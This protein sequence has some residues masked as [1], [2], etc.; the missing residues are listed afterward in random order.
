[1]TET[2]FTKPQPSQNQ[3]WPQGQQKKKSK[4]PIIITGT[5]VIALIA[6][7]AIYLYL[8]S[9]LK[10]EAIN[11]FTI[12][13][14]HVFG[15]N[16]WKAGSYDFSIG[17]KKLTA[18]NVTLSPAKLDLPSASQVTIGSVEIV[19]GLLEDDM[20]E[21]LSLSSWNSPTDTHLADKLTINK[22]SVISEANDSNNYASI[23]A[24]TL[25]GLDL[26]ANSG[27]GAQGALSF[28]QSSRLGNVVVEH[29]AV[30]TSDSN[31]N[32]EFNLGRVEHTDLRLGQNVES[33]NDVI[34]MIGSYNIKE[35]IFRDLQFSYKNNKKNES[36]NVV[37]GEQT[38]KDFFN[39]SGSFYNLKNLSFDIDVKEVGFPM[40]FNFPDLTVNKFDFLPFVNR[41]KDLNF[42]EVDSDDVNVAL[43]FYDKLYRL[44]DVIV[45]PY[46]FDSVSASSSFS[47]G[48]EFTATVD[49]ATA[50]GPFVANQVPPSASYELK[51][52]VTLPT[53]EN[54]PKLG[55]L[56][57]FGKEFGQRIFNFSY[58][59]RSNYDEKTSTLTH[60][61]A[62]LVKADDLFSIGLDF[63]LVNLTPTLVEKMSQTPMSNS[64]SLLF[65]PEMLE[66]G[67]SRFRLEILDNSLVDK[68]FVY[69]AKKISFDTEALKQFVQGTVI[70]YVEREYSQVVESTSEIGQQL[71][72]FI[73]KPGSLVVE[74]APSRPLSISS[75]FENNF[76]RTAIVNSL[77]GTLSVNSQTPISIRLLP[78]PVPNFPDSNYNGDSEGEPY[79]NEDFNFETDGDPH[80]NEDNDDYYDD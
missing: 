73:D 69:A 35:S 44:S 74:I 32:A 62:P 11:S 66:L 55:I 18:N 39:F 42:N 15:E 3:Q 28:I 60:T 13:M 50:K 5:L 53:D 79:N 1:M 23:E 7:G 6:A 4:L 22:A 49:L 80:M 59:I 67:L 52:T 51:G 12:L 72:D 38:I 77:N 56:A 41:F 17:G 26:V 47:L 14:D 10:T 33:L 40:K 45:M 57:T 54:H 8:N 31:Q 61:Y 25:T 48:D 71:S 20:K 29:V 24:V 30:K 58:N 27:Q 68:T 19:N 76:D 9:R 65:D 63:T 75:A 64:E 70:N 34:G 2:D 36:F 21:L 16:N 43:D 37:L 46:S 78:M